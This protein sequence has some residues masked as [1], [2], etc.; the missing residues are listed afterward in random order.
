MSDKKNLI[1]ISTHY[2]PINGG[3]QI[4]IK[5]LINTLPEYKHF[6]VQLGVDGIDYPINTLGLLTPTF[7]N[8]K[9]I[10]FYA[11]NVIIKRRL[12]ELINQGVINPEIDIVLCHY[13]FHLSA[14]TRFKN[15]LVLSHG[16]EWDGPGSILRKIYH[17]H[18][19][20]INKIAINKYELSFIAND[21]NYYKKLGYEKVSCEEY[22]YQI[23]ENRWLIPNCIDTEKF[24]K[25]EVNFSILPINSIIVPRN[26]VPQRGMEIVIK[27]FSI[28]CKESDFQDFNLIIIGATYDVE[29]YQLL[30]LLTKKLGVESKVIF[31]GSAKS[32][33]M[34]NLFN[35]AAMTVIFSLFREGTSLAALESMSCGTPVITSNV[36]GLKEIP[37]IKADELNLHVVMA[38]VL[39]NRSLIGKRQMDIVRKTYNLSKWKNSWRNAL[40]RFKT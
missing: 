34:P 40:L 17:Y 32:E 9:A 26:I 2:Y 5:N 10:Q 15:I 14:V 6:V 30:K 19:F 29:Y 24:S 21:I 7:F 16:V 36:G 12:N 4:Y 31:Y 3:Q 13:A 8:Y 11:F 25:L 22:F 23:D 1:H 27:S 20:L 33:D 35:S 38:D 18:R 28:L 37:S 39:R